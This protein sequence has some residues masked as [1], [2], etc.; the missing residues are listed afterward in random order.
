MNT[1]PRSP[2]FRKSAGKGLSREY[3]NDRPV[4]NAAAKS[5]AHLL[6]TMK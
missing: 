6:E 3:L 2:K 5:Q 1:I 4:D